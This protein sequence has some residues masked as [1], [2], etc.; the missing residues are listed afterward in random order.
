MKT[1]YAQFIIQSLSNRTSSLSQD[2]IYDHLIREVNG[3]EHGG[4]SSYKDWRL[5][6]DPNAYTGGLKSRIRNKSDL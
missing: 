5:V 6:A 4:D 2:Y 3:C 1:Y